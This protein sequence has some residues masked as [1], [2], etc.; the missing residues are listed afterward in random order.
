M[1]LYYEEWGGGE[2]SFVKEK[3]MHH[4]KTLL[5]VGAKEIGLQL[6]WVLPRFENGLKHTIS[7]RFWYVAMPKQGSKELIS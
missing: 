2:G 7:K 4:S 6:V 5:N 1:L 3:K